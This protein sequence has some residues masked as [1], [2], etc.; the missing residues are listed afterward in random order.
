MFSWYC[1]I[2]R[3]SRLSSRTILSQYLKKDIK[4]QE[5]TQNLQ[6]KMDTDTGRHQTDIV[7]LLEQ[8]EGLAITSQAIVKELNEQLR[9]KTEE[10][11]RQELEIL[12]LTEQLRL[13]TE[14]CSNRENQVV[15]LENQGRN[16]LESSARERDEWITKFSLSEQTKQDLASQV[17][18]LTRAV[19]FQAS[20]QVGSE[21]KIHPATIADIT[22]LVQESQKIPRSPAP[23]DT[24]MLHYGIVAP[25]NSLSVQPYHFWITARYGSAVQLM[26]QAM[27]IFNQRE[28]SPQQLAQTPWIADSLYHILERFLSLKQGPLCA[29]VALQA[30]AYLHSINHAF[31]ADELLQ[32]LDAY[33]TDLPDSLILK[34]I[35]ERVRNRGLFGNP[36]D[37]WA[38]SDDQHTLVPDA[39]SPNPMRIVAGGDGT[40]IMVGPS[41]SQFYI[42]TEDDVQAVE[43]LRFRPRTFA[44]RMV[45][46][47]RVPDMLE[48]VIIG[49]EQKQMEWIWD[50]I[51]DKIKWLTLE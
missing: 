46:N 37:S 15:A 35:L 10:C 22:R 3:A 18:N 41:E 19:S 23:A 42:F 44:L 39:S 7:A 51:Y 49:P 1:F 5:P 24:P 12:T 33:A 50:F 14:E 32:R 2:P 25:S 38:G 40:F 48:G 26:D 21:E 9:S 43:R 20:V 47:H 34:H 28:Y 29:I 13:K 27:A 17:E 36:I 6:E 31:S 45:P 4:D 30:M 16:S 8:I 11:S